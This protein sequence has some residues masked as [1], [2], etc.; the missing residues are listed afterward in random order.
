M[1][2]ILF[3][4][5]KIIKKVGAGGMAEVF[6]VQNIKL[7]NYWAIKRIPNHKAKIY[8]LWLE[9][10]ILKELYHPA[11]PKVIDIEEDASYLYIIEE[12]IEGVSLKEFVQERHPLEEKTLLSFAIQLG[13]VIHYLHSHHPYPIIYQDLKPTNL[14][15]T[16][17]SQLKLIDFGIAQNIQHL[18]HHKKYSLGTRGYAAPEQYT[19]KDIDERADIYSLGMT[20]YFL[21]TGIEMIEEHIEVASKYVSKELMRII[22]K[23][24]KSIPQERYPS[25]QLLLKDLKAINQSKSYC[26]VELMSRPVVLSVLGTQPRVGVTHTAIALGKYLADQGY[27]VLVKENHVS[28]DF[29]SIQAMYPNLIKK[30]IGFQVKGLDFIPHTEE[31]SLEDL[32]NKSY[33]FIILDHGVFNSEGLS[34]LMHS[35]IK[36]LISGGKEWEIQYLEVALSFLKDS[37]GFKYFFNFV[38]QQLYKEL[39]RHMGKLECFKGA[40]HPNPFELT[41]LAKNIYASILKDYV[42][43]KPNRKSLRKIILGGV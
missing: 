9:P 36:I 31:V 26:K 3:N 37:S 34:D 20:L 27:K 8:N 41:D 16:S 35:N 22:H 30:E 39:I 14:I 11:I 28:E 25:T 29:L 5:Y 40:Y 32:F 18:T 13:E 1:C 23:C 12:F 33:E 15:V 24:I 17:N 38:T 10:H 43:L 4:K 42:V 21:V 19:S 6:L 2:E 7:G